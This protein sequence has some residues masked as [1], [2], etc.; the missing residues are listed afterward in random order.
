MGPLLCNFESFYISFDSDWILVLQSNIFMIVTKFLRFW[1]LTLIWVWNRSEDIR[2]ELHLNHKCHCGNVFKRQERFNTYLWLVFDRWPFRVTHFISSSF[3][4]AMTRLILNR[5]RAC[6][7]SCFFTQSSALFLN[8]LHN[9]RFLDK[10]D[11]FSML[12]SW[13]ENIV[14]G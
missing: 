3:D 4:G 7:Q 2:P 10:F 5:F 14:L 9:I 1:H 8:P 13:S 11:L 6:F 12:N